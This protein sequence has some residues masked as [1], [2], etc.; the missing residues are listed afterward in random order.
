MLRICTCVSLC[1]ICGITCVLN[2]FH[3]KKRVASDKKTVGD[4]QAN[5]AVHIMRQVMRS[6]AEGGD[7]ATAP[8]ISTPAVSGDAGTPASSYASSKKR[9]TAGAA[10][11][12]YALL[13]VSCSMI[14]RDC[15]SAVPLSVQIFVRDTCS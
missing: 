12:A 10:L 15:H 6:T 7:A 2:T 13:C 11:N 9:K 5:A 14:Y 1:S 4:K 8:C 3:R